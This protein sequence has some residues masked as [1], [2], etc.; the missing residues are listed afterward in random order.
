[1]ADGGEPQPVAGGGLL[2]R[3]ALLQRG[4]VLASAT[5]AGTPAAQ[6]GTDTVEARPPWMRT[7]GQPF[8]GYGQP[9]KHEAALMR[10]IAG[11]RWLPGNGVSWTPL[12]DLEGMITPSGLHFE[13]HHNGV[14]QIDP[15]QHR[16][17]I[18]GLVKQPLQFAVTDLERYPMRS[19]LGFIECGGNSNAGWHPEPIQRSV[20]GFHGLV[21]CNEW[22][23]VRVS[24]LLNEAGLDPKAAW[25]I[26]EGGD[27]FAMNVSLP[28]AKLMDDA[29][30]ALYQNGEP[31]RPEHGYPLRLVVPGWEGVLNVKWLRRLHLS[32]EPVMARNETAK[33]T[34]LQSDG[35]A[36]QF[37][38]VM[39]AKSLITSP[40]PGLRM[41]GP[42][43]Y[44]IRGLAWSGRGRI[45]K[46]DVSA[47]GGQSWATAALQEPVLP[48]CFT[49]F[50]AAWRWDGKPTVIKS[51]ATDETGYVQ[52]E[53]EVLV[54]ERGLN[55]YFHYNAIVAWAV[56]AEGT[57]THV[58]A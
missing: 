43:V 10:T 48:R 46:V 30:V 16:L 32:A 26:A 22:T 34:E 9:S 57:L 42:N 31:I 37:T 4:L 19:H 55:G 18:H 40:S 11:N 2:H 14:P 13:R 45:R 12:E 54:Q 51:R 7:P 6:T 5:A 28:L 52:P 1:D 21:S 15:K 39:D 41:H 38:F 44:E 36:R 29:L 35:H 17:L 49:R 47:D 24:V 53:R 33:Y 3:R 50:R 23:G 20:G 25:A 27:A 56:D 8:T 58:Y